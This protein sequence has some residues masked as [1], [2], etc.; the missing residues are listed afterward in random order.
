MLPTAVMSGAQ[1]KRVRLGEMPWL[2]QWRNF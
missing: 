1:K 2:Q